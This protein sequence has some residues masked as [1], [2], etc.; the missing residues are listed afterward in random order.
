MNMRE[1]IVIKLLYK[2]NFVL[3]ISQRKVIFE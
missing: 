1:K 2:Y 3:Y